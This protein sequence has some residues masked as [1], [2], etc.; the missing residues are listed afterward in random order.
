MKLNHGNFYI[1]HLTHV[2]HLDLDDIQEG[3]EKTAREQGLADEESRI[4]YLRKEGL[5]TEKKDREIF[6]VQN[7]LNG[8][9]LGRKNIVLPSVLNSINNQIK[10]QEAK[11]IELNKIK[12]DLIGMTVETYAK[13]RINDHYIIRSIYKDKE[14]KNPLFSELEF[15]DVE[16]DELNAIIVEYNRVMD[17]CSDINLKK[18]A[19]QDFYQSYYYLCENN[20]KEFFDRAIC[21]F[22]FFQIR[23]ANYS[24]YFSQI[25]SGVDINTLPEKI[26]GEPEEIVAYLDVKKK[27]S[28]LLDAAGAN[29]DGGMTSIVGA[30]KEDLKILSGGEFDDKKASGLPS[31][32]V[33]MDWFIKNS[34]K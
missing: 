1:R 8:M 25:L 6:D 21:N 22:T 29:S 11:L 15:D 33:G 20:F 28:E 7:Y 17:N 30:T 13:K 5:W 14:F 31:G 12:Y 23:L 16:D 3:F 26:R 18:L 24:R 32:P 2:D 10:E 34:G 4:Q 27:G 19:I 9:I